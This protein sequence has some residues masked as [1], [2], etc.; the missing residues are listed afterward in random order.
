MK[1]PSLPLL[2]AAF[3]SDLFYPGV[4]YQAPPR[5][6]G[7]TIPDH[8]AARIAAAEAKRQRKANRKTP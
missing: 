3:S 5:P 1:L 8:T 4:A 2:A 6:S 7:V